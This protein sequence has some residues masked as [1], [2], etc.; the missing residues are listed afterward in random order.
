MEYLKD[1]NESTIASISG[2]KIKQLREQARLSQGELAE[3]LECSEESIG[4]VER[5]IQTMKYWR[6]IRLCDLFHVSLDFLLR[7]FDPSS[8]TSVPTYVVKLFH[9][10]DVMELEILA[11]HLK[12][13]SREIERKHVLE[14]HDPQTMEDSY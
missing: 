1:K 14:K 6:L 9:D 12:L 2:K 11:D 13:A 10:A 8:M 3:I 4:K 7:D 5:G